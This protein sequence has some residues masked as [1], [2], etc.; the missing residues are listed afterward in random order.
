M[1]ATILTHFTDARGIL[2]ELP[3]VERDAIRHIATRGLSERI[4]FESGDFFKNVPA[5]GDTYILSHVIHDWND[6]KCLIIL[7]NCRKA[8]SPGSRLLIIEMVLPP[9]D[10]PHLGKLAD[11]EMLVM[12][13]GQERTE[14]EYSTLLDQSGFRLKKVIPTE[15]Q[16]SIIEAVSV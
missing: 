10:T 2:L 11:M 6:D 9:G 3:D 12:S 14:Q 8:M 4:A 15:S 13:G 1:L 16:S 5:G 7:G